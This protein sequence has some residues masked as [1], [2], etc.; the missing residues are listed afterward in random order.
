VNPVIS[1]LD[2]LPSYLAVS[3]SKE[4]PPLLHAAISAA[5]A[6]ADDNRDALGTM[7]H[8]SSNLTVTFP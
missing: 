7:M 4:P 1:D 8:V 6:P 3:M 2:T 5:T